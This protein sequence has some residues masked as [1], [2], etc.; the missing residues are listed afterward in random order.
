MPVDM[1]RYPQNWK[2]ISLRIRERANWKCECNSEC[3]TQ[4]PAG[5]CNAVHGQPNPLTNSTVILTVAHLGHETGD[6]HDKMDVRD[7]NLKAMCQRCHLLFDIDEHVA[8]AKAT[9]RRYQ[10]QAGQLE[11]HI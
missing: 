6:K 2:T 11:F 9:R 8:N 5:R 7:S 4:H 3:G 10:I 1:K